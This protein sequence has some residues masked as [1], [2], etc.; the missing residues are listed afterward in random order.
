LALTPHRDHKADEVR[1]YWLDKINN[2]WI[3]ECSSASLSDTSIVAEL[4]LNVLNN[5]TFNP[6]AG[7][8]ANLSD[9]CNQAAGGYLAILSAHAGACDLV[10]PEE[11]LSPFQITMI[12]LSVLAGLAVI[13]LQPPCSPVSARIT[14]RVELLAF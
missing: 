2:V 12:I 1:I 11:G 5:A 7:C 8:D 6:S 14:A 9:V 10:T 3:P 13:G 4:G